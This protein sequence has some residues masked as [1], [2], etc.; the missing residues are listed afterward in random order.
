LREA[1]LVQVRRNG[2]EAH[3]SAT[4]K[5][6]SPLINWLAHYDRFWRDRGERLTSLLK[7]MDQ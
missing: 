3:Y 7:E 1:G 5:G 4:A 6:L 2:R